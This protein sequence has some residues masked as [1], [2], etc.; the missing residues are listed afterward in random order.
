MRNEDGLHPAYYI[1]DPATCA[2]LQMAATMPDVDTGRGVAADVD[3]RTARAPRCG[4][5]A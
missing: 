5:R 3:A 1:R 2:T 4:R